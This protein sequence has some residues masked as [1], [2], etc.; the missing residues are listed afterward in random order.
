MPEHQWAAYLSSSWGGF[1]LLYQHTF[2][3]QIYTQANLQAELPARGVAHL[4]LSYSHTIKNQDIQCFLKVQNLW[5]EGYLFQPF[6]PAP[7][8]FWR[9][10]IFFTPKF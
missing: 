10:G 5:N 4:T 9:W 3:S 7:G 2:Q 6:V 8:R 1:S